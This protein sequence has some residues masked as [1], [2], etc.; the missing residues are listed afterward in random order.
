MKE[1]FLKISENIFK[2]YIKGYNSKRYLIHYK[3][4]SIPTVEIYDTHK[5]SFKRLGMS[6]SNAYRFI[7]FINEHNYYVDFNF[8]PYYSYSKWGSDSRVVL[9]EFFEEDIDELKESDCSEINMKAFEKVYKN[10]K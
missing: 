8:K 10:K 9:A 1:Q 2:K 7:Y 3:D 5:S 6:M 4:E